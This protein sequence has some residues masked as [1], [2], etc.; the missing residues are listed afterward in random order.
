MYLKEIL[1]R[2][3]LPNFDEIPGDAEV[4]AGDVLSWTVPDTQR[5][6]A[7]SYQ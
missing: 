5:T 3:V 1:D 4:S 6:V 7:A 2:L